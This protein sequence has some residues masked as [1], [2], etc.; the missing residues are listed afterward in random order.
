VPIG[1]SR[2][3]LRQFLSDQNLTVMKKFRMPFVIL[4]CVVCIVL[5]ANKFRGPYEDG[6]YDG[7]S[8]AIYLQENYWGHTKVTIENGYI[9]KID[10]KIVDST[11][12]ELF[13]DKY[14]RYFKGNDLYISQCRN[15]WKGVQMYPKKL[16]KYQKLQSVDAVT[17]ATWSYNMFKYSAAEA[18]KKAVKKN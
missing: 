10:F 15:D 9:T 1:F 11:K 14:E 18:L 3:I 5:L 2:K 6:S 7:C 16:L 8:R 17:G 12:N 13:D 4:I